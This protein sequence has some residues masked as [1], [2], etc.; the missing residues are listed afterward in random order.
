MHQTFTATPPAARVLTLNEVASILRI[1]RGSAYEAAKRGEIPTIRFGRRLVVPSE[2]FEKMLSGNHE[3][4]RTKPADPRG[5]HRAAFSPGPSSRP[6]R[7]VHDDI[8]RTSQ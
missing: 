1:S 7:R 8:G 2:A 4:E 3:P 6:S 5:P